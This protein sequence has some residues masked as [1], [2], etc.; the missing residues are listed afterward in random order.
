[1]AKRPNSPT[2]TD[3]Q[4]LALLDRYQCPVPFHEVRARLLGNIASPSSK[5]PIETVKSLWGG[6]LPPFDSI[7]EANELIGALVMGLWNRLTRHQERSD[8]FRLK[9]VQSRANREEIMS[10]ATMRR[11]E[12]DGFAE[13]LF[14]GAEELDLSE[15][16]VD[17]MTVLSTLRAM[18]VAIEEVT[19]DP[20]K[21]ANEKDFA[22]TLDRMREMTLT[23]EKSI[24]AVVLACKRARAS[25]SA[26]LAKRSTLH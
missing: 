1:M 22:E 5:S 9:R 20:T 18:F 2:A 7:D 12:L 15:R 11:Q 6:E 13:G 21:A 3:A 17:A 24:H 14:G 10:L 25:D 4:V 26:G 16:A 8:P 23:A 19:G